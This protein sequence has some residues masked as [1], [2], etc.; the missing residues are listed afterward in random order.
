MR[1][2]RRL[3]ARSEGT[4]TRCSREDSA[5]TV[6]T[7]RLPD[8]VA[9]PARR[10][11]NAPAG[12]LR[13]RGGAGRGLYTASHPLIAPV[14]VHLRIRAYYLGGARRRPCRP[15]AQRV[16]VCCSSH[17]DGVRTLRDPSKPQ[18]HMER[19]RRGQPTSGSCARRART[20]GGR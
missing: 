18:K 17:P 20:A 11:K 14:S 4:V 10:N 15:G 13:R 8:P 2:P 3:R 5:V 19:L 9:E 7:G 12:R 1:S 6:D 16:R